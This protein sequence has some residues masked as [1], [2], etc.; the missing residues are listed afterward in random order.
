MTEY[1]LLLPPEG[2]QEFW[3]VVNADSRIAAA[4]KFARLLE[5]DTYGLAGWTWEDLVP[6]VFSHDELSRAQCQAE[7]NEIW[8]QAV[9]G[10]LDRETWE[11]T[12]HLDYGEFGD[13]R[14]YLQHYLKQYPGKQAQ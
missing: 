2:V 9:C 6:F 14:R 13:L 5:D 11:R 12:Q 3:S 7:E 4:H 10:C 1:A 8:A